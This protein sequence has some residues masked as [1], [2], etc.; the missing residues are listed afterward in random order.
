MRRGEPF[1][2]HSRTAL[3]RTVPAL[4]QGTWQMGER[5]PPRATR[6]SPRLRLGLD[7]GLTLIDTAEMYGDGGA[8]ELVAEAIAGR[9]DEVFLVSKVYPHNAS[10]HGTIAACERSL[11]RLETDR[12]D[13]YLLHWR[14]S[15]RSA[16]TIEAFAAAARPRKIRHWGVSNF[17]AGDMAELWRV[18]GGDGVADRPG[19]LQ[20]RRAA[21]RVRAAALV[22]RAPHPAHGLLADRSGRLVGDKV[23]RRVRRAA[24]RDAGAGRARVGAAQRRRHR[25]PEGVEPRA[26][27]RERRRAR[28]PARRR[29]PEAARRRVPAAAPGRNRCRSTERQLISDCRSALA[30]ASVRVSA[31][32]FSMAFLTCVLTVSGEI[33]S[34]L[35]DLLVLHPV[36]EQPQDLSLAFRQRLKPVRDQRAGEDAGQYGI[37][38]RPAAATIRIARMSSANGDSFSR[39][40]RAPRSSASSSRP[41]SD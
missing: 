23:V 26:R 37:D 41:R 29:R 34:T 4:G 5:P 12:L 38:V 16:E 22:P 40:P 36:G 7:L 19:A 15:S 33:E 31:S 9:R 30:T 8:E 3:G 10:R 14:G 18:P 25:D 39:N 1:H 27:A 6:R 20:P 32:S 21:S 28:H 35:A 11:K 2:S 17:D 13:L 24:R